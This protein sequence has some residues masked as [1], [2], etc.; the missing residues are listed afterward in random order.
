MKLILYIDIDGVLLTK[1]QKLPNHIENFLS[2][3]TE[4]FDCYWLTTH[5]KGLKETAVNYLKKYYPETLLPYIEKIKPTNWDAVKTDAIDFKNNFLW[6]D[7]Y[8]LES[9]KRILAKNKCLQSLI[10]IDFKS[11]PNALE[12]FIINKH[13]SVQRS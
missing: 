5:C 7:D 6:L 3:I 9:E 2:F 1:N 13:P 11:N 4:N 8:V 12:D 10:L